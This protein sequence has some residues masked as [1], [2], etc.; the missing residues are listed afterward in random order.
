MARPRNR[1]LAAAQLYSCVITKLLCTQYFYTTTCRFITDMQTAP[2]GLIDRAR[3]HGHQEPPRLE[4]LLAKFE[5]YDRSATVRRP[6]S[7][8]YVCHDV[9]RRWWIDVSNSASDATSA[10]R[11]TSVAWRSVSTII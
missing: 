5:K 8:V 10:N 6:R 9:D 2:R 11:E 3:R 4:I 1:S 7:L